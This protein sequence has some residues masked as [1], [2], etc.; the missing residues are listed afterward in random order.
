MLLL[1]PKE[2]GKEVLEGVEKLW[3]EREGVTPLRCGESRKAGVQTE[4][5]GAVPG[6]KAL[7]DA[8]W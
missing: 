6:L 4:D 3:G 2:G 7:V 5:V 8:P 1:E